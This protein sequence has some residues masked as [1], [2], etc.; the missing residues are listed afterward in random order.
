MGQAALKLEADGEWLSVSEIARRCGIHRQ[1]CQAR[2]D[3]LG[4]EPD[5]ERSKPKSKVYWFDD[6]M[7]LA[8][9]SAKDTLSA[10]K[11]RE[12]RA[13]ALKLE[14][15]NAKERSELVAAY[16]VTD[17]IQRIVKTLYD[18]YAVRQ[19]KRIAGQLVKAKTIAAVRKILKK[20]GDKV[21]KLMRTNFERFIGE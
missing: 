21:M 20:D 10:M 16:E 4:Y 2:L 19:P 17:I 11:I 8:V 1:T 14:M 9:K 7:M 15:Q 12:L 5:E 18:E 6:E 13:R 3:D